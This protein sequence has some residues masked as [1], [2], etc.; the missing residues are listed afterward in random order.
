MRFRGDAAARPNRS[1]IISGVMIFMMQMHFFV[2]GDW[3]FG[4]RCNS[5]MRKSLK[6]TSI[7]NP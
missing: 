4:H 3:R 6:R 1:S 2:D 5:L 7:V